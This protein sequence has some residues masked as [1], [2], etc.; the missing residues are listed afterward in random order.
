MAADKVFERAWGKP[1]EYDPRAEEGQERPPFDPSPY[2]LEVS[3]EELEQ[4]QAAMLLMARRQGLLL[5]EEG[6]DVAG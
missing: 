4:L 1:E 5:P 6:E 2:T 3:R